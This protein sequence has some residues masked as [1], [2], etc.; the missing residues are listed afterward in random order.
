MA[1]DLFARLNDERA[2][3]HLAPL[4]WDAA[5]ANYAAAWSANM[6]ANGFRHSAISNLLGTYNYVGEN[7]A[8]GGAGTLEGALHNA[9]MHSDGHRSN[10]LAPGF[11]RVGVG[12]FCRADGSIFLT[13]DFGHPASAGTP[14]TA[15]PMPPVDPIAR[16]D[17][18]T[19]HC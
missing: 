4:A 17:S 8:A 14:Q 1:Q 2:A 7:I 18:G 9:W 16:P 5:L 12:V 3:R 15:A 13:Q 10:I 11:T 19:L 6:G